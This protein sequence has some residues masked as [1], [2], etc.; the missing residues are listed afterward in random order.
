M[1]KAD[2]N[3]MLVLST[4]S[5]APDSTEQRL[6]IPGPEVIAQKKK[7][8]KAG[9]CCELQSHHKMRTGALSAPSNNCRRF[10]KVLPEVRRFG[11]L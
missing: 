1:Q 4:S 2:T 9:Y 8:K 11:Q 6:K 3:D 10:C 5:R 7:V